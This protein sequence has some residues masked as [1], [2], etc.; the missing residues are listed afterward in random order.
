MRVRYYTW[1]TDRTDKQMK[2]Q[3]G[4]Q[5]H[6]QGEHATEHEQD[7]QTSADSPIDVD[8]PGQVT[9]TDEQLRDTYGQNMRMPTYKGGMLPGQE[10]SRV[11]K[12]RYPIGKRIADGHPSSAAHL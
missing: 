10:R 4:K 1:A 8:A 6:I 3:L 2:Q 11:G 12:Y 9:E 5:V 7:Q